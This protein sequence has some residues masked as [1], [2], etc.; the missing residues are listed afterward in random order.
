MIHE[1]LPVGMLACN[2][3]VFGDEQSREAMVVDPGDDIE[4]VL[5]VIHRHGLRAPSVRALKGIGS[6]RN[7]RWM[8]PSAPGALVGVA[9]LVRV[10]AGPRAAAG[11]AGAGAAARGRES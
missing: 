1:I 3:S 6:R 10:G 9:G 7:Q 2:C 8:K 11:A 4:E 5:E